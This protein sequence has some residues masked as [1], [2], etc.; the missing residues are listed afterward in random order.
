MTL[1]QLPLAALMQLPSLPLTEPVWIIAAVLLLVLALPLLGRAIRTPDII[2]LILAGMLFGPNGLNLLER[3]QAMQVWG[4]VGLLYIMFLA[5]IEV[6]VT[7][8][9]RNRNRSAILGGLSFVVPQCAGTLGAVWLLGFDWTQ[10]ILLASMLAS[11][12]LLTYP[13]VSRLGLARRESVSVSVGGVLITDT[14]ALLV[15]AVIVELHGQEYFSWWLILR[16]GVSFSIFLAIM[17]I[18]VPRVGQWFFKNAARDGGAQFL[19]V[20]VVAFLAG[21]LSELAGV[22]SIIGAFLAGVTLN[23]LVPPQSPLMNRIEFVGHNLFIPFFL[24]SVGMIV[25][26]RV[27][28]GDHQTWIVGAYMVVAVFA[29]KFLASK[30]AQWWLGYTNDEGWVIFGLTVTQAAATLAAVMIGFDL[31]IFDKAVLN[32]TL[33]MIL[34]TCMVSPWITEFFGRRVA[35]QNPASDQVSQE[36][37]RILVPVDNPETAERIIDL[38]LLLRPA[39]S[40]EPLL[41]LRIV[42]TGQDAFADIARNEKMMMGVI[43]QAA[44]ADVPV[45]PSVRVAAGIAEGIHRATVEL[46]ASTVLL[47]WP[48]GGFLGSTLLGDILS[49]TLKVCRARIAVCQLR[50]PSNTI[51]LI[52][53]AVPPNANREPGFR[54]TLQII[55]RLTHQIGAQLTILTPQNSSQ[56]LQTMAAT[57]RPELTPEWECPASWAEICRKI[58]EPADH[59]CLRIVITARPGGLSWHPSMEKLPRVLGESSNSGGT[60]LLHPPLPT[61]ENDTEPLLPARK[62]PELVAVGGACKTSPDTS[63][64]T[65][66]EILL[67]AQIDDPARKECCRVLLR[68]SEQFPI[69]LAPGVGLVHAHTD[70]I[71]APSLYLL[72]HRTPLHMAE[73]E[74]DLVF[75]LLGPAGGTPERHLQIL[76][77]LARLVRSHENLA[78]LRGAPDNANLSTT[79]AKILSTL[80]S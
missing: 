23:R 60:L 48:K 31:G 36:A 10:A 56:T 30:L 67:R 70:A 22:E 63:L 69:E 43:A 19:F 35:L 24:I 21:A 55:W 2:L 13:Q 80:N 17:L 52:L 54:E 64:A 5:G 40:T 57:L 66:L 25:D 20:L 11:F 78:A 77:A 71:D 39:K 49:D 61:D 75:V 18:G 9:M 59:A 33:M 62:L 8:F 16:L 28:I 41:P 38:A 27:F 32:G 15:L 34:A 1:P 4:T 74:A 42:R 7:D 26:P 29:T 44:A 45:Q 46:R 51:S 47:G 50:A 12:T 79:L 3:G 73:I 76:S 68:A 14:L 37:G 6:N 58:I 65:A 72:S 53:L